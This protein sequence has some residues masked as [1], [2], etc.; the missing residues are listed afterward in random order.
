M[1][2]I[3]IGLIVLFLAS[4]G[5]DHF[6]RGELPERSDC[7]VKFQI[8]MDSLSTYEVQEYYEAFS[9]FIASEAVYSVAGISFPNSG[10]EYYYVQLSDSCDN[11]YEIT[12][13]MVERFLSVQGQ[14]FNYQ[15]FLDTVCPSPKTISISGPSWSSHESCK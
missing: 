6:G 10:R 5:R 12:E 14:D 3:I 13:A 11:K 7:I 1:K 4:C 9:Y 8:D 2:I 15:V